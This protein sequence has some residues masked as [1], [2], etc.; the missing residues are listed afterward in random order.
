MFERC[1]RCGAPAASVLSYNYDDRAM[2]LDDLK[3]ATVPGHQWSLCSD[4]ADRMT[5]PVGWTLADRRRPPRP[6]FAPLEVA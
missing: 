6:L 2:W 1:V 3:V 4:H 5:P